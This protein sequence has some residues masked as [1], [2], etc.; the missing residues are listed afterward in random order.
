ML[1]NKQHLSKIVKYNLMWHM[2]RSKVDCLG[3]IWQKIQPKSCIK[4]EQQKKENRRISRVSLQQKKNCWKLCQAKEMGGETFFLT[5]FEYAWVLYRLF[6]RYS[7]DKSVTFMQFNA[8]I[9]AHVIGYECGIFIHDIQHVPY[10]SDHYLNWMARL[11]GD[12][13]KRSQIAF[14]DQFPHNLIF[15]A[16]RLYFSLLAITNEKVG[17]ILNF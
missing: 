17:S 5:D 13:K 3:N 6:L 12:R 11:F 1:V 14:F 4:T 15:L 10:D 8:G 7:L 9:I 16:Q 2:H